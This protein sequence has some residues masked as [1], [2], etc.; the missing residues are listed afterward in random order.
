MKIGIY[1]MLFYVL[2]FYLD[3]N[4]LV[5]V[6]GIDLLKYINGLFIY[7]MSVVLFN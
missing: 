6:R 1:K 3:I 7:K 2:K 5:Y 4:I